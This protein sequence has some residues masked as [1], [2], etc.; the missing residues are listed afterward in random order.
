MASRRFVQLSNEHWIVLNIKRSTVHH[1]HRCCVHSRIKEDLE[2]ENFKVLNILRDKEVKRFQWEKPPEVR[3]LSRA[4]CMKTDV[5]WTSVWPTKAP[6]RWGSVPLPIRQGYQKKEYKLSA[7]K[8]GNTELVK[9]PNFLH[10]TPPHI[11][12]HCQA[13]KKF[14]TEF[15]SELK[16]P[17]IRKANFPLEVITSD[18]VT[19]G[20]SV[21][22]PRSRE[23]TV[24]VDLSVLK[25]DEHSVTK[26]KKLAGDKM[27]E[28]AMTLQ[29]KS[30]RC[31]VRKQNFDF[32]VYTLT[33]LYYESQEKEDW[34][35]EMEESD[36]VKYQWD[37]TQ[38]K[39]KILKL[40]QKIQQIN[41]GEK[42]DQASSVGQID[43]SISVVETESDP[44][45]S[46][47]NTEDDIQSYKSAFSNLKDQGDSRETLN[48]YKQ[49]FLK[50]LKL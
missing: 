33:A 29:L 44:S 10:L 28:K 2:D 5:N 16:T 31:P 26:I 27:D 4:D 23:V 46:V 48:A 7:G 30:D 18:Y 37:K 43:P 34:E 8:Y 32:N 1:S 36:W 25:F 39:K 11:K 15:P 38:S 42:T 22:D 40:K 3:T 41:R 9:I 24:N 12:T 6:F 21:R 45:V 13:I 20:T 35:D 50:L 17:E 14:C 49:A 19:C 47:V